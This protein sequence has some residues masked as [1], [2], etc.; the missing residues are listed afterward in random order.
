MSSLQDIAKNSSSMGVNQFKLHL[1]LV[2][3]A[4]ETIP[5]EIWSHPLVRKH[6]KTR[7]KP[8]AFILF[9]LSFHYQAAKKLPDL[10][11]RGRPDIVHFCL[12][13]ALGS[14]L[15]KRGLLEVYVHTYS[16]YVIWINPKTRL[17]RHYLRFCGLIEQLFEVR[18]VPPESEKPLLTL[19]KMTLSELLMKLKPDKVFLLDERGERISATELAKKVLSYSRPAVMIGAFQAGSFREETYRLAHEV[20]SIYPEALDA[21]VVVARV[22]TAIELQLGI[23]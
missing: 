2:E 21:W 23:L 10:H 5:R 3:A 12:L 17:P 6:S 1:L 13:E 11:K 22:L 4:L 20:Y 18:K 14:P 15:N 7:S 16:D 8:P 19:E 9:D